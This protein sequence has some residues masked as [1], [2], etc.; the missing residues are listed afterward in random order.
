MAMFCIG[1]LAWSGGKFRDVLKALFFV[2]IFKALLSPHSPF[3][4]Y[5]AVAF[6]GLLGAVL[7]PGRRAFAVRF[8]LF[9]FLSFLESAFQRVLVLVLILG[10]SPDLAWDI[11]IE[12]TTGISDGRSL[13]LWLVAGW[14]G[15]HALLGP[16]FAGWFY[17]LYCESRRDGFPGKEPAS[18]GAAP[19]VR[20]GDEPAGPAP[21]SWLFPLMLLALLVLIRWPGK[22]FLPGGS[23]VHLL[24][25][26]LLFL[27][28]WWKVFQPVL[29]RMVHRHLL[30]KA[31]HHAALARFESLL[32]EVRAAVV[33]A[34]N[35]SG[36]KRPGL[37]FQS[38]TAFLFF[39]PETPHVCSS[40][41]RPDGQR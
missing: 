16:V 40:L 3:T 14:V 36:W 8:A 21:F 25:F 6:Q 19:F 28:S 13:A 38:L 7:L 37:F 4:A 10:T 32:P 23:L 22:G 1:A 26:W 31:R 39:T 11:W 15:M 34:W 24:L 2:L 35:R 12:K 30:K 27:L 9:G 33:S 17:R 41:D 20:S 29:T 5:L 18:P